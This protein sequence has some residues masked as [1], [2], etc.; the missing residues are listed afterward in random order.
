MLVQWVGG[1][2][3]C[4]V[5]LR[6]CSDKHFSQDPFVGRFSDVFGLVEGRRRGS[7]V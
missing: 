1:D 5:V 3:Y 4:W 2:Q 7:E 6:H